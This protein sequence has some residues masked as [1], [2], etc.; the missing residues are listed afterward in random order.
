MTNFFIREERQA[1][2]DWTRY[3]IGQTM[4]EWRDNICTNLAYRI[5]T[6]FPRMAYWVAL[7]VGV[8]NIHDDETVPDV[9]HMTVLRRQRA[10]VKVAR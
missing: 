5:T 7:I 3:R 10:K 2:L 4:N 6:K 8:R 1:F 9:P